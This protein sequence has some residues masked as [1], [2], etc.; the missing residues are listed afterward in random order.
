M[1]I[2]KLSLTAKNSLYHLRLSNRSANTIN[3]AL[4]SEP[5]STIETKGDSP[6]NPSL[7][8]SNSQ[9]KPKIGNTKSET[10]KNYDYSGLDNAPKL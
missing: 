3:V 4:L 5:S 7:D 10:S 9:Y 6:E 1:L 8:L 2:D